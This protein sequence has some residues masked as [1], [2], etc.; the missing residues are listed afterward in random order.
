MKNGR[1]LFRILLLLG[2]MLACNFPTGLR[3]TPITAENESATPQLTT[4]PITTPTPSLPASQPPIGVFTLAVLVDLNSEPVRR[5]QAQVV[6]GEASQIFYRLTKFTL[7][8]VDFREVSGAVKMDDILQKYLSDPAAVRSDGIIIFSYGDDETAKLYG[9]YAFAYPGPGGFKSRFVSSYAN[10]NSIYVSVIHFGHRYAACGYGGSETP[11]S[12]VSI[13]GECRGQP[14][15][16]CTE[17]YGYQM[18]SLAVNDLA[19]STPT[20]F[21]SSSFVHEIMHPFGKLGIKDHYWTAECTEIM[22]SGLSKRPYN[23]VFFDS[24]ESEQYVNMCPYVFDNF[25]NSYR[26]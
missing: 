22:K 16:A 18:C 17:K 15:I 6:V 14:G 24:A 4:E 11:V 8:M 23:D 13:D 25:V 9:G 3:E 7:E 12:S 5:E 10:P 1:N 19:A 21:T 20:Y 2:M 26:P